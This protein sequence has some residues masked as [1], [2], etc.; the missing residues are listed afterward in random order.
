MF[1][2]NSR[3]SGNLV[4]RTLSSP[5][6]PLKLFKQYKIKKKNG[7]NPQL[8]RIILFH[9]F[10]VRNKHNSSVIIISPLRGWIWLPGFVLEYSAGKHLVPRL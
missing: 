2:N 1:I 7:D 8:K 9:H 4:N 6:V 3:V 10:V 5:T